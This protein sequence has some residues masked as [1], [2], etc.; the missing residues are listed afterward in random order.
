MLR[1][2]AIMTRHAMKLFA[3]VLLSIA[4]ATSAFA[5]DDGNTQPRL[6]T[7]TIGN[8]GSATVDIVGTTNGAGNVKGVSCQSISSGSLGSASVLITVNGGSAQTLNLGNVNLLQDAGSNYYTDWIPLNV[9]FTSSIRVQLT[10]SQYGSGVSCTA[11]WAL[12]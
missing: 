7:G 5:A 8:G 1:A 6:S 11:S 2:E 10:G 9:R 12:D 3:V 4:A